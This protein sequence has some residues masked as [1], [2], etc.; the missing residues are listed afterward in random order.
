VLQS[1]PLHSIQADSTLVV[2]IK[3]GIVRSDA[4]E[5]GLKAPSPVVLAISVIRSKISQPLLASVKILSN[6]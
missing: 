6:E 3:R 5:P 1:F 2:L 4:E